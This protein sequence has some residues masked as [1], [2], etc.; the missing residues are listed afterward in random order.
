[1]V[2]GAGE[3]EAA[4]AVVTVA[5]STRIGTVV[6]TASTTL[7][8]ERIAGIVPPLRGGIGRV[9]VVPALEFIG[10]TAGLP[11]V[12]L[13]AGPSARCAGTRCSERMVTVTGRRQQLV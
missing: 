4:V 1:M 2:I 12:E 10:L 7:L 3:A 9:P 8:I 6:T 11:L 5:P 13:A